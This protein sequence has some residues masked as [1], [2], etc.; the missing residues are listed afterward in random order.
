MRVCVTLSIPQPQGA[1]DARKARVP[2][3]R[4]RRLGGDKGVDVLRAEALVEGVEREARELGLDEVGAVGHDGLEALVAGGGLPL[5]YEMQHVLALG[6]EARLLAGGAGEGDLQL[7]EDGEA[8][9]GVLDLEEAGVEAVRAFVVS[10]GTDL[11]ASI[12]THLMSDVSVEMQIS[13][14]TPMS[15]SGA[16]VS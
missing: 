16:T 9:D 2:G 11:G 3:D 5:Q 7:R 13:D 1:R 15:S 10:A 4:E 12:S 6:G 8:G 14:V